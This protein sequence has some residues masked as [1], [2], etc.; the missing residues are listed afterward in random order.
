MS[1]FR[2]FFGRNVDSTTAQ[3]AAR[4]S[5]WSQRSRDY[6]VRIHAEAPVHVVDWKLFDELD[7]IEA[8][9]K[10]HYATPSE[11]ISD[12]FRYIEAAPGGMLGLPFLIDLGIEGFLHKAEAL[13]LYEMGYYSR[14]DILELGTH[15]GLSTSILAH[16]M[17]DRG[18]GSLVTVDIEP[19]T[20]AIAKSNL[21]RLPGVER[22]D[23]RLNDAKAAMD[24][25]K[26]AD[27]TFGF[28]FVDHWH[29][30]EATCDAATR[31]PGLLSAGGYVMFHDF[32]DA[33]NRDPDHVY[34]VYQAVIDIF[35]DD[36][37]FIFAGAAGGAALFLK[38]H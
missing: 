11:G 7:H 17:H 20:N 19:A 36:Q 30:Y 37:R 13:T 3:K 34:G 33:S 6:L 4:L 35:G 16:A 31:V 9:Y 28:I 8:A 1:W 10:P 32:F 25:L 24:K 15:K 23:F 38:Q 26:A 2:K 5:G 21:A 18:S 29:G 27:R 12:C 14:G 22:I